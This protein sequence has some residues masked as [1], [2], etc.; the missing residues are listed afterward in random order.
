MFN[1]PIQYC[2]ESVSFCVI[3]FSFDY[4]HP[5]VTCVI[6]PSRAPM[7]KPNGN[8]SRGTPLHPVSRNVFMVH[9][10]SAVV[11]VTDENV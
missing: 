6:A 4:S 7:T 11:H 5:T 10:Q 8:T 9:Q 3:R 1:M 2:Y